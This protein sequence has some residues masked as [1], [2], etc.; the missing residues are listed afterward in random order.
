MKNL[1]LGTRLWSILAIAVI[2]LGLIGVQSLYGLHGTLTEDRM[3]KT[4]NL[5]EVAQ[6][7]VVRY[8]ARAQAGELGEADAKRLALADLETLRYD[9]I[10]YFWVNDMAPVVLMH[11]FSKG[12]VGKNVGEIK[13]PTGKPLFAEMVAVVKQNGAGFVGYSW[14][15]PGS[16]KPVPKISYVKGFAPWGWIIGTGIYVDDIE[17]IFLRELTINGS[18]IAVVA[19]LLGGLGGIVIRGISKPLAALTMTLGRLAKRDWQ[20]DVAGQD[21]GDEIGDIARAVSVLKENGIEG[22]R[23]QAQIETERRHNEEARIAQ[24][25]ALDRSIGQVVSAASGGDLNRRIEI[26]ELSGVTAKIGE[27]INSLLD[28][29]NST[30]SSIQTA[31]SGLARGDLRSRMQGRYDGVFATLQGDLNAMADTLTDVMRKIVAAVEMQSNASAEISTGS[32]DLAGRTEQQA[33]ALEQTAASM[34][35]VTATVKLNA[36]NAQA[37]NQL[38]GVARDTATSG[39]GIVQQAVTAMAEIEQSARRI[40]DIIGLI[41]EIA[42]QTNLLALNASVE[43]ARAGEAGKGFAVVAQEVRALAQRSANASKDIK[44]LITESNAQVRSGSAL[45]NQ[46]G[47]S[48]TE[49]VGAV[50]KVSDIVAE[51]AAASREQ[52]TGLE[53]VNIAVGNMDEMT[54]RNGALVEQTSASAQSLS[55]QAQELAR[56]VAFFQTA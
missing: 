23:L 30:I 18:I 34:H 21:R 44:S 45:V 29:L 4:R 42:F 6:G 9:N 17:T 56:L 13:D 16:E 53:E 37:A 27:Q 1:R 46:A 35:E 31:V 5:A 36:D 55:G 38:A 22:D 25:A 39:G 32:Q 10:E 48:L 52:A 24:E 14:P 3:A 43:A 7:I 49:I 15:K 8:H 50:K 11:P 40:S 33:A 47:Q 19:L 54:Q 51:I 41:D 26:A 12:L 20:A 28:M 2:G